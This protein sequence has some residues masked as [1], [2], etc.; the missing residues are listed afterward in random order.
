MA[1]LEDSFPKHP[2]LFRA[3]LM[4]KQ[5]FF[6]LITGLMVS[7]SFAQPFEPAPPTPSVTSPLSTDSPINA[8]P[9]YMKYSPYN[10]GYIELD[11]WRIEVNKFVRSRPVVSPDKQTMAYTE[12]IFMPHNRQ[13]FSKLYCVP[14]PPPPEDENPEEK[15]IPTAEELATYHARYDPNHLLKQRQMLLG[16]GSDESI[17]Y[18]FKTLTLIDWSATGQR[19]LLKQKSG[20]LHI[21]LRTSDIIIYDKIKGTVTIYPEI[22]RAVEHYWQEMGN[23]A[24]L[25]KLSW[26]IFPLGWVPGSDTTLIFKGWAFD[27]KEKKFLGLWRYDID[28]ERAELISLQDEVIPVAANGMIATPE[29]IEP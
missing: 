10:D 5:C 24:P 23:I 9:D 6:I 14:I 3:C 20:I 16:V 18:D 8:Q 27:K 19:L 17:P 4:K 13:T 28:S 25:K 11:L 12:V 1:L 21:G 7:S 2:R 22:H 29:E 15:K 26:D